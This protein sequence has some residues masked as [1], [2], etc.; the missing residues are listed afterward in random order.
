MT[1][2]KLADDFTGVDQQFPVDWFKILL[3][4]EQKL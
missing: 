1:G 2:V 3:F 4:G